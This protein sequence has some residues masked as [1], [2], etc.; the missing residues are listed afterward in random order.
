MDEKIFQDAAKTSAK[1]LESKPSLPAEMKQHIENFLAQ[2]SPFTELTEAPAKL[3]QE[4]ERLDIISLIH[5]E[6]DQLKEAQ[7]RIQETAEK[8]NRVGNIKWSGEVY[9]H[10]WKPHLPANRRDV[11]RLFNRYLDNNHRPYYAMCTFMVNVPTSKEQNL[12]WAQWRGDNPTLLQHGSTLECLKRWANRF[13]T[14]TNPFVLEQLDVDDQ[15]PDSTSTERL[16]DPLAALPSN[17]APWR[18]AVQKNEDQRCPPVFYLTNKLSEEEHIAVLDE[19]YT[20]GRRDEDEKD[21]CFVTW[22]KEEDGGVEDMWALLKKVYDFRG[23][24]RRR[25]SPAPAI[26]IDRDSPYD[27][28]VVLADRRYEPFSTLIERQAAYHLCSLNKYHGMNFG[29]LPGREATTNW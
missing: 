26:F 28:Q 8:A 19:L 24:G 2:D 17:V 21:Y 5:L 14:Y 7:K 13:A 1:A 25:L 18:P 15:S 12:V 16:L 9:I 27:K 20:F 23:R 11:M 22:E 29:R 10:Q 3:N 6:P 4:L